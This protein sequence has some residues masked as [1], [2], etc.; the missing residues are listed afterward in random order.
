MTAMVNEIVVSVL[1][2]EGFWL[3]SNH[4]GPSV[5]VLLLLLLIQLE[6]VRLNNGKSASQRAGIPLIAAAPLL[7]VSAFTLLMRIVELIR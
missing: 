2:T 5:I 1:E 3:L 7:V 6:V 4:I